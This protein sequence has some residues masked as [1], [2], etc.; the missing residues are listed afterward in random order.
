[1][2]RPRE[3]KQSR[4]ATGVLVERWPHARSLAD[5]A[6]RSKRR[7]ADDSWLGGS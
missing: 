5:A 3:P 4:V 2:M 1:M 7:N 6:A